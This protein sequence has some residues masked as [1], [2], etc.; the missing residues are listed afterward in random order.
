[1]STLDDNLRKRMAVTW[2]SETD[3]EM[4]TPMSAAAEEIPAR[5]DLFPLVKQ[6][7]STNMKSRYSRDTGGNRRDGKDD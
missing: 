4:Y 5:A 6:F 3:P 2:D 1:M 7:H